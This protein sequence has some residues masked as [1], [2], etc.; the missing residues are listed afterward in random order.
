MNRLSAA[1][2]GLALAGA[3]I[4]ATAASA[5]NWP[6]RTVR[7]INPYPGGGAADTLARLLADHFTTVFGQPFIVE[8]RGGAGGQLGV[9]FVANT[10]P[11]G[12]NFVIT[13]A[14][15]LALAPTVNPKLPYNPT[16][17]LTN[18]AYVAGT[19]TVFAVNA[20]SGVKTLD[21]FLAFA[22]KSAKPLAYSSSGLG[23]TGHLVAEAFAKKLKLKV[24]HVPYKGAQQ[25]LTDLAG[26][27]IDFASQ[28]LSSTAGLIQ[29]G[30]LTAVVTANPKR[31]EDYPNLPTLAELGHPDLSGTTWF[32]LSAPAKLPNDIV[33][34]INREVAVAMAKPEVQ[35]MMRNQG[36]VTE[37]MSVEEFN[38]FIA[39]EAARWKP[40]IEEAGLVQQ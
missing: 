9:Q 30:S 1:L 3:S 39:T 32:A 25:G 26:G 8:A 14:S 13:N 27:H 7:I 15:L 40:V 6:N 24:E 21:E 4:F 34:K 19:P 17:D 11:D 35:Q 36:L 5:Q 18:I 38:K 33:Q 23:T 22:R 16:R 29:G 28:T 20:K 10:E 2:V 31:L 12:Y 37:T